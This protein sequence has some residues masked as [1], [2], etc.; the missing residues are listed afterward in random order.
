MKVIIPNINEHGNKS[1]SIPYFEREA[2]ESY[3]NNIDDAKQYIL[4]N[5]CDENY[6]K[7]NKK[8]NEYKTKIYS[9]V[10]MIKNINNLIDKINISIEK[11]KYIPFLFEEYKLNI[12]YKN[13]L[14]NMTDPMKRKYEV[15]LN[16]Y[17]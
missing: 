15:E 9:S 10:E 16:E 2:N 13:L 8:T 6:E 7:L 1:T 5:C 14:K 11:K 4:E 12:N 3:F 17:S